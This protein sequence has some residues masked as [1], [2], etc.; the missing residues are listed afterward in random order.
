MYLM[1]MMRVASTQNYELYMLKVDYCR[2]FVIFFSTFVVKCGVF[3]HEFVH[4]K[5]AVQA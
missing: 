3:V 5:S 2:G 1:V 4:L